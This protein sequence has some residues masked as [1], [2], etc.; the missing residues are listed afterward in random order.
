MYLLPFNDN[1]YSLNIIV[2]SLKNKSRNDQV[3]ILS[4]F[5]N[6][7]FMT[8]EQ[9]E[10][11]IKYYGSCINFNIGLKTYI[12][13]WRS[14][15]NE[16]LEP[17]NDCDLLMETDI[18]NKFSL[19]NN[20]GHKY[21]FS[22]NDVKH[23]LTSALENSCYG[24]PEPKHPTNPYTNEKLSTK[25]IEDMITFLKK[26][27]SCN[28]II[29]IYSDYINDTEMMVHMHSLYFYKKAI[30]QYVDD[31][32]KEEFIDNIA[33]LSW[34]LLN[35]YIVKK[36]LNSS[37]SYDELKSLF[38]SSIRK[39]YLFKRLTN[40]NLMTRFANEIKEEIKN[41]IYNDVKSYNNLINDRRIVKVKRDRNGRY[42]GTTQ[43]T[44]TE[45]NEQ[46][47]ENIE[48]ENESRQQRRRVDTSLETN[49]NQSNTNEN[50]DESDDN[51]TD[52]ET[53]NEMPDLVSD[54]DEYISEHD[55]MPVLSHNDESS[56][57]LNATNIIENTNNINRNLSDVVNENIH[58]TQG[59]LRLPHTPEMTDFQRNVNEI[60]TQ[61][62]SIYSANATLNGYPNLFASPTNADNINDQPIQY[63]D[64][65]QDQ[66]LQEEDY[67]Y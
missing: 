41:I 33:D 7:M 56:Y 57:I 59:G 28:L 53:D 29:N 61:M 40:R 10:K 50:D 23:F 21:W 34:R 36:T 31:F 13:K 62:M 44:D 64:E 65:Q 5:N 39:Y 30:K 9:K 26:H 27:N 67:D 4:S 52:D 17:V 20:A 16:K 12:N 54:E 43:Q 2:D 66:E 45:N 48:T 25:E 47:S 1:H 60:Y 24:I 11:I 32:E 49:E 19:V 38:G 37:K 46:E 42:I 51:D 35:F 3:N 15:K 18:E 63:T 55:E 14:K 6:N 22:I 8:P 58:P